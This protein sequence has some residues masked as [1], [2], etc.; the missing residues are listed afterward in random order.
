DVFYAGYN[1]SFN[2]D[3]EI[4]KEAAARGAKT[5]VVCPDNIP[6]GADTPTYLL[7]YKPTGTSMDRYQS[8]M[9]LNLLMIR[10]RALY[11]DKTM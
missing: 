10:H 9:F 11:I 7:K 4:L 3:V 6:I 2:D 5:V 8:N 1:A